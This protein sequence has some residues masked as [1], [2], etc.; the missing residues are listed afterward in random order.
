MNFECIF[1]TIYVFCLRKY[2]LEP[3]TLRGIV[4]NIYQDLFSS[5]NKHG[6]LTSTHQ[7][8]MADTE[9]AASESD[10][11]LKPGNKSEMETPKSSGDENRETKEEVTDISEDPFKKPAIFAAPSVALK[12]SKSVLKIAPG[13]DS[14][15]IIND[16]PK[17]E[18]SDGEEPSKE[19]AG[20]DDQAIKHDA[21]SL[22]QTPGTVKLLAKE[23]QIH[24]T[25][26]PEITCRKTAKVPP[27]GK[28]PPLPY[29]EPPWAGAPGVPYT[30]ELLKNGAI[31][32]TVP[33]TQQT[34]FVV[35]RLPVCD[36]SLEHPSISRY[37]AVVQYR[38]KAGDTSAV[39]EEL[40]FYIYDLG[41]T[42]GTFVNK[43]KIPP[44]TYTRLH[45][46]HVLKF[47]GSTRL[48]ILQVRN[49]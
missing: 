22:N 20:K 47:G 26:K 29:T 48:F 10:G 34:Y 21:E 32:D 2:F 46:G 35:G 33:L 43:N 41:S 36:I 13:S 44:K 28:F 7:T 1:K 18:S 27:S 12:K 49:I 9:R 14:G 45:V 11:G 25:A 16:Q 30:F 38:G 24:T 3:Y 4:E 17:P 6:R 40:G 39:G 5:G 8:K 19:S 37:H 42:H 15:V 23:K 31:L